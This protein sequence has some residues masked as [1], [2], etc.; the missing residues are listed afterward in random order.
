MNWDYARRLGEHL[1]DS[2]STTTQEW[3]KDLLCSQEL[4]SLD[5]TGLVRIFYGSATSRL[6]P[7]L[8]WQ[9]WLLVQVGAVPAPADLKQLWEQ[10]IRP[11]YLRHGFGFRRDNL[12][13]RA[14]GIL[15]IPSS[16][17]FP[18]ESQLATRMLECLLEFRQHGLLGSFCMF[19]PPGQRLLD[20]ARLLVLR[21]SQHVADR[22]QS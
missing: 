10:E 2:S 15:G 3:L 21:H 20:Q 1:L 7:T 19:R 6:L 17:M 22:N 12:P 14:A 9:T 8:L 18:T 5:R 11:F 13:D 16:E 4:R